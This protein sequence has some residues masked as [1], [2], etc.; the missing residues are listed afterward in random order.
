[1]NTLLGISHTGYLA[2]KVVSHSRE[3]QM[4]SPPATTEPKTPSAG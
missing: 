4:P 3:L 2:N 1:M